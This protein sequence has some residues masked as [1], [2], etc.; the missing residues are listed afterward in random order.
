MIRHGAVRRRQPRITPG[1]VFP[2]FPLRRLAG[3]ATHIPR[4]QVPSEGTT[5]TTVTTATAEYFGYS[6]YCVYFEK[7][8]SERVAHSDLAKAGA[9]RKKRGGETIKKERAP[10]DQAGVTSSAAAIPLAALQ[11]LHRTALRGAPPRRRAAAVTLHVTLPEQRKRQ[12]RLLVCLRQ[13]RRS[14]LLQDVQSGELRSFTRYVNV[15][16]AAFCSGEVLA[17]HRQ[18]V[19]RHSES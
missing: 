13:H 8:F 4:T 12:A 5:S 15:A 18:V 7:G 3:A 11:S 10:E 14:G 16:D 17:G 9:S 19:N 2:T 1:S 6:R